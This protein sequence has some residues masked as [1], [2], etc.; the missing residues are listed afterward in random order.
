M[1]ALRFLWNWML[2][3]RRDAY[4]A[5]EG[6]IRI[7]YYEQNAQLPAM[8]QIYPWLSEVPSQALQQ[9]LRDLDT[10]FIAFFKGRA[11]YPSFKCKH[12]SRPGIHWPQRVNVNGRCVYLPKLGWV[13]VRFSRP[14]EGRLKSATVRW[15]GLHWQVSILCALEQVSTK[16]SKKTPI[17]LDLGVQ[18]SIAMSDGRLLRLPV[19]SVV[20]EQRLKVL[21]QRIS[22][23]VRGSHR[24]A[25]AK[26]RALIFR[27]RI[28]NRVMDR[29]HKLTT[30]LAQNHGLIVVEDLRLKSMT[31]SAKGTVP[32]PGRNVAAKSRLNRSLLE[33][34]H[35]ETLRQLG[36]KSRWFGGTVRAVSAA[37]TSQRCSACSHVAAENRPSRAV[38][39]CTRC[40]HRGHADVNAAQ[41]ILSAGLAAS[42]RVAEGS[43][44]ALG[45]ENLPVGSPKAA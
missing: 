3:Q 44:A 41:N 14:L 19:A 12:R 31:R 27:R 34:G 17:G 21:A 35:A 6:R 29:R 36:Y 25:K 45:S 11:R 30:T 2:A 24:H 9:T 38:F 4:Q 5:S 37:Y 23:C 18:E 15:D 39:C 40:G 10:A 13:K 8:K 1:P 32:D 42:A 22:R 7:G 20:E 26:R 16:V 33:Q 43:L 28:Q